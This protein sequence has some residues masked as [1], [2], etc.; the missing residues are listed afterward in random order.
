VASSP[1]W[2]GAPP[3]PPALEFRDPALDLAARAMARA[4]PTK[5]AATRQLLLL[6]PFAI[7]AQTPGVL[8]IPPLASSWR[9]RLARRAASESPWGDSGRPEFAYGSLQGQ[10]ARWI[11]W[12]LDDDLLLV[13]PRAAHRR[14]VFS[15]LRQGGGELS[16]ESRRLLVP[17]LFESEE[18][19]VGALL[20]FE[21]AFGRRGL[22][23]SDFGGG[24]LALHA[25]PSG[26]EPSRLKAAFDLLLRRDT[27]AGG[28]GEEDFLYELDALLSWFSGPGDEAQL[29][30]DLQIALVAQLDTVEQAFACPF[31]QPTYARLSKEEAERWFRAGS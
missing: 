6:D 28:L 20:H 22:E 11:L 26:M 27:E 9:L 14:L 16:I 30:S 5:P 25:G 1:A 13:D 24:S 31:G 21:D 10:F 23:I 2:D 29:L 8:G 18:G 4:W 7:A 15:N 19:R 17:E 3:A 12:A